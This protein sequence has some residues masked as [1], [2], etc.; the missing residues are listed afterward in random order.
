[1]ILGRSPALWYALIVAALNA[2]VVVF[3]VNLTAEQLAALNAFAL[4]IL[5]VIANESDPRTVPTLAPTLRDRRGDGENVQRASDG[6]TT[7]TADRTAGTPD[8]TPET[9]PEVP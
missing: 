6:P 8:P 9:G 4:A 2:G 5:G 3:G 1:M 7:T